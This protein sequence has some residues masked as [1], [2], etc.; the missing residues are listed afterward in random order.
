MTTLMRAKSVQL[1]RKCDQKFE[2]KLQ[3]K[4]VLESLT[5]DVGEAVYQNIVCRILELASV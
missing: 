1:K 4:K 2:L 5:M 3:K